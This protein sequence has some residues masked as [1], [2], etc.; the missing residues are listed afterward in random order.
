MMTKM[1]KYFIHRSVVIRYKVMANDVLPVVVAMIPKAATMMVF[2]LIF[3]KLSSLMVAMRWPKPSETIYELMLTAI[4]KENCHRTRLI[5]DRCIHG[6]L[7]ACDIPMRSTRS[8]HPTTD[9]CDSIACCRHGEREGSHWRPRATSTR[10]PDVCL[11]SRSLLE[12]LMRR[13][14]KLR[15]RV[16]AVVSAQS[17]RD[18]H[19][20]L[21]NS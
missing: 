20:V 4:T 2:S 5:S 3:A 17:R 6:Q 1:R 19:A 7:S 10:R 11:Y 13:E 15:D 18:V 14:A 9:P 12:L 16:D 8:D 21:V